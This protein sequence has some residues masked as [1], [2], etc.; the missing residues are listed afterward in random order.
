MKK[1]LFTLIVLSLCSL[2]AAQFIVWHNG[3]IVYQSDINEVDSITLYELELPD[4]PDNPT[5]DNNDTVECL[6][7]VNTPEAGYITIAV[8][9]PEG[10]CNGLIAVGAAIN[11]DATDDWSPADKKHPFERVEGTA[12]WYQITLMNNPGMA[13]KVIALTADG[14]A[15]WATQWGMNKEGE[16]PNV[17]VLSGE[18]TIDASENGGE[19]KL[20]AM[21]NADLVYV[22]VVAWKS[23]PCIE[24]NKEGLATFTLT[25][26]TVPANAKVGIIGNL[27]NWDLATV[28]E[29][30]ASENGVYTAEAQVPASCE[31]KYILNVAEA[32]YSWYTAENGGNRQ[33]SLD[34]KAVDTV[35][36]WY[37]IAGG[38]GGEEGE[39]GEGTEPSEPKDITVKAKVPATW[40]NKIT[41]WV[42][43]TGGEGR[44]VV[45][46]QE[47][48]W[49][50]VTENCTELNIIFKNGEGWNGDANQTVDITT[51][52]NA[53][54][55]L[56]QEGSAK[57][58]ATA[59]DCE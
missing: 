19:V 41:T 24:R 1:S 34:L 5:I 53:C 23:Q 8:C 31:Y 9:V 7:F 21:D 47:G 15:D 32:G 40:T 37:G 30:T 29:M 16:D 6:P 2:L 35:E 27:N 54:Y 4:S 28:I 48:D 42:W 22:D 43:P 51:L 38:E 49:Y 59:V 50:V 13:V 20:T 39:G 55:E 58:T 52:E 10:T 44:E 18:A 57:A 33:M 26:T 25:S 14:I 45:P 12:T 56:L 11:E 36:N 3:Q 46:T 17:I